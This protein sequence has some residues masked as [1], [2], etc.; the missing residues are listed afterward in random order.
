MALSNET[1]KQ[2]FVC[3][4]GTVYT[5]PFYFLQ[6][7]DLTVYREDAAGNISDPLTLTTDYT[8][9]GAGSESGGEL[10]TVATYSDGKLIVVRD[11][12]YTQRLDL[13]QGDGFRPDTLEQELDRIV[14]QIQQLSRQVGVSFKLPDFDTSGANTDLPHPEAGKVLGWNETGDAVTNETPQYTIVENGSIVTEKLAKGAVTLDKIDADATTA[15]KGVMR[16]STDAETQTGE[17]A[18]ASV[19]PA[20]L[21]AASVMFGASHYG[22]NI[23]NGT[24]ASHDI[25][26]SAGAC[27]DSTNQTIITLP[28]GLTKQIDAPWAEGTDAGGF[29][30][31]LTLETSVVARA[32]S[33]AYSL[34]DKIDPGNGSYWWE[35]TTAGTSDT[36]E[37]D[38]YSDGSTTVTD[39][40]AV[41]EAVTKDFYRVFT[42][43]NVSSG[44][45]DAGFDTSA[46]AANLLADATGYTKYRQIGWVLSDGA[47][48]IVPFVYQ[49]DNVYV[50]DAPVENI[51]H[52]TVAPVSRKAVVLTAP[53]ETVANF[54]VSGKL[55]NEATGLYQYGLI[56]ESRQSDTAPSSKA[57]N[58]VVNGDSNVDYEQGVQM[59][60]VR[61]DASSQIQV[62]F[63]QGEGYGVSCV[64]YKYLWD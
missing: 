50:W 36:S 10:T 8:L 19:T 18:A 40:T 11:V 28:T 7:S 20:S 2:I 43:K 22:L 24:D 14:M 34:G 54:A 17:T 30:S 55:S 38:G 51:N 47:G 31:G 59:Y 32:N 29:P 53:P 26:I 1:S 27:R 62:R 56:T 41:F 12:D 21:S 52:T 33:T 25:D 64:G 37:P 45:V 39:G 63:S 48:G 60:W 61:T 35:C 42:I 15:D 4:G 44:A 23:A 46:T 6:D 58:F 57:W 3:T 5:V 49:G 9:T 13:I 16:F